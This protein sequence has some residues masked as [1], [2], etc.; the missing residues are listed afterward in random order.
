MKEKK[1][2]PSTMN[3][4]L[5]IS[6]RRNGT[7][8]ILDIKGDFTATTGGLVEEAYQQVTKEGVKKILLAFAGDN[9]INSAGI[10]VLISITADSRDKEQT[11]RITGLSDHFYK[12][13][14]MVG[15]TRYVTIFPSEEAALEGF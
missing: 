10:A 9:Y 15:L 2:G 8:S 7:V 4:D 3:R 12:I 5:E 6:I 14:D 11:I 1:G 13:F